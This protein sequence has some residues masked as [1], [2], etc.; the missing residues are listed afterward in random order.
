VHGSWTAQA[1][2]KTY[3]GLKS[4]NEAMAKVFSRV[5]VRIEAQAVSDTGGIIVLAG[6]ALLIGGS[7]LI[8]RIVSW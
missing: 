3:H 1:D 4:G 6:I 8:R 5:V 2:G 7:L